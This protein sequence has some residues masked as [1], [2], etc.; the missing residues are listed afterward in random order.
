[1][2]KIAI[3]IAV[4]VIINIFNLAPI[5]AQDESDKAQIAVII[6]SV[7]NSFLKKDMD[8]IMPYVSIDYRDESLNGVI[9]YGGFKESM[10][11]ERNSMPFSEMRKI[12]CSKPRIIDYKFNDSISKVIFE[13]DCQWLSLDNFKKASATLKRPAS[14]VKEDSAWKIIYWGKFEEQ[15]GDAG[16]TAK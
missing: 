15:H 12:S 9:D 7:V 2:R 5:L 11:T 10:K 6:D 16:K 1:M 8:G 13:Q 3:F 4:A 14:F